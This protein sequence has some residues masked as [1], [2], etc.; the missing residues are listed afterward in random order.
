MGWP[1]PRQKRLL[2]GVWV[3]AGLAILFIASYQA[4]VDQRALYMAE[5]CNIE[6]FRDRS[7]AKEKLASFM[8]EADELFETLTKGSSD[9]DV[10]S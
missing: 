9:E 7:A 5:R 6:K 10:R 8:R 2:P 4:W 1:R 3:S